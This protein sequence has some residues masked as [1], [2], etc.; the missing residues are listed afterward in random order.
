VRFRPDPD[1]CH[2]RPMS[3]TTIGRHNP[4]LTEIRKA[5][6]AGQL[7]ADGLLPIEGPHMI[8]EAK[9]SGLPIPELFGV[10]EALATEVETIADKKYLLSETSLRSI[11]MMEEPQGILALVRP[12]DFTLDEILE[13]DPEAPSLF[14]ALCGLQDPGNAGTILR[15][16][17][18]FGA[19]GC[20]ATSGT[21]GRYNSKLVRASA[22]SLFRL[23]HVWDVDVRLLA[24]KARSAGI[25]MIGTGTDG[26]E[27]VETQDWTRSTALLLGNE[28]AG[29]S[30]AERELCDAVVHIPHSPRVE[31]LNAATAAAIILYEA[32]R[33]R[34][35]A[36]I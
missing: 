32:Q 5:L 16:G 29:L 3:A 10:E 30:V 15:L 28:G 35:E 11:S 23:P 8:E 34:R 19:T 21:A 4:R 26:A 20:I 7:T 14:I 27:A 24:E 22:G 1:R 2:N 6:R 31:S 9:Q 18:A 33:R 13:A 25:Q 12:P 17:E 36:S